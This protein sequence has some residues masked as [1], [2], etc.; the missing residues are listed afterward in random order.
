MYK[1]KSSTYTSICDKDLEARRDIES[2]SF[3]FF[4][5]GKTSLHFKQRK[6]TY[7]ASRF[8]QTHFYLLVDEKFDY[9]KRLINFI[10]TFKKYGGGEVYD[11]VR[12]TFLKL[13]L[14]LSK[15][16][17]VKGYAQYDQDKHVI[18]F[19]IYL[20]KNISVTIAKPLDHPDDNDVMFSLA[21][22]RETEMV[23]VAD[24]NELLK[25]LREYTKKDGNKRVSHRYITPGSLSSEYKYIPVAEKRKEYIC[26]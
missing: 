19:T 26:V 5:D 6:P 17:A 9:S 10:S 24:F 7:K 4:F 2:Y 18:E 16:K 12:S 11:Y 13:A 20:E 15:I 1:I 22:S 25:A 23:N 3:C 8:V 21:E 14:P